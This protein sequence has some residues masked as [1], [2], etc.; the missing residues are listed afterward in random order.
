MNWRVLNYSSA[1]PAWNMAVDEAVFTGYLQEKSPPTLRFYGWS[2][3]T[4]SVG[5][6]QDVEREI[7]IDGLRLKGYGLVRRNTGGRAVLHDRE[8]TYSVIAGAREA[9]PNN[10]MESYLYISRAFANAL[11]GLGVEAE[12][13]QGAGKHAASG[14]CFESPSWYE[15][16][17][18]GRKLIGSAQFRHKGSFLQHGSILLRFSGADLGAVLQIPDQSLTAFTEMLQKK[19]ISLEEIGVKLEPAELAMKII[20]SFRVMYGITFEPGELTKF[21][22]DLAHL[23]VREKYATDEWNY[24]RG[25]SCNQMRF[26]GVQAGNI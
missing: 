13:N 23:L 17:V 14:A 7:K 3:A 16:T 8:L 5:Y 26:I 24:Q 1:D 11:Q 12:L 25:N 19:I 18:K 9:L 4:V 21:E 15:I 6:F 20:E 10:L 2:P 22:T